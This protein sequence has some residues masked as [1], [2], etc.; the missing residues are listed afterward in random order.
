[1]EYK[2]LIRELELFSPGM[3]EK[4]RAVVFTKLDTVTE[5]EPLDKLQRQLEFDGEKVFRVSSVSGEG[6]K[7][8][9]DFLAVEVKIERQR[10]NQIIDDINSET[11]DPNSIWD[12]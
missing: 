3:L 2:T 12:D 6:I 10:E 4:A 7:E 11:D 5:F 8:L 1:M 9:L